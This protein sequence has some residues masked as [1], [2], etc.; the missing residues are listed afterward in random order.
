MTPSRQQVLLVV[1]LGFNFFSCY[2]NGTPR[3]LLDLIS[4]E[5]GPLASA[6]EQ[7]IE[8]DFLD[9]STLV[10][11]MMTSQHLH[12]LDFVNEL[13]ARNQDRYV[14]DIYRK[15]S[16]SSQ[17]K[18]QVVITLDTIA[19]FNDVEAFITREQF[20]S[21]THILFVLL[22]GKQSEVRP[23]FDALWKKNIHNVNVLVRDQDTSVAL[24]TFFPFKEG[25]EC[26]GTEP[27]NV[28]SFVNGSFN[29]SLS[30]FFPDKLSDL[31]D[32]PVRVVTFE[33]TV[34]VYR[35]LEPDG[36]FTYLGFEIEL[37]QE[38]SRM[39]RFKIE[40][41]YLD[42]PEAWG[43]VRPNGSSGGALGELVNGNQ[44]LAIGMFYMKGYRLCCVDFSYFYYSFPMVFVVPPGAPYS[45]IENIFRPFT[46]FVWICM[47]ITASTGFFVIIAIRFRFQRFKAFVF[48]SRVRQPLMNM[49][50]VM[51]GGSQPQLPKRNFSRFLLAMFLIFCLVQRNVY[52]GSL[53]IF[54]KSDGMKRGVES[55]EEIIQRGYA[56]RTYEVYADMFLAQPEIMQRSEAPHKL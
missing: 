21:S 15:S 34:S 13:L 6:V 42:I 39:F 53:Y 36:N 19:S 9:R 38:I 12:E 56:V 49:L 14:V 22:N 48:G 27:H 5:N 32:C 1:L 16:I 4:S 29:V 24:M 25:S 28:G 33:D 17:R 46:T 35:K 30:S 37:L 2:V 50:T 54:L 20:K 51:L 45:A 31:Q 26:G 47:L 18:L 41:T 55:F 7:L 43:F 52:Q 11:F 44:D 10:H 40:F 3:N 23:I 8:K